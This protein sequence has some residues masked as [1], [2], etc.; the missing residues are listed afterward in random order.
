MKRKND[1]P[2]YCETS[3]NN[4]LWSDEKDEEEEEDDNDDNDDGSESIISVP[5]KVALV[6]EIGQTAAI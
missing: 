6:G 1:K 4:D 2:S 3:V 5:V